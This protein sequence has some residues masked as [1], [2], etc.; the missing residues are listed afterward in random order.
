MVFIKKIN[1]LQNGFRNKSFNKGALVE[2][3]D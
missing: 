3:G 2:Y 1:T